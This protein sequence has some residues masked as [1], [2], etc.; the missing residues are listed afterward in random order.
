MEDRKGL[1]STIHCPVCIAVQRLVSR[2]VSQTNTEKKILSLPSIAPGWCWSTVLSV[3]EDSGYSSNSSLEPIL[4]C[5]STMTSYDLFAL[6]RL[7]KG[8]PCFIGSGQDRLSK[9]LEASMKPRWLTRSVHIDA[10]VLYARQQKNGWR[11]GCRSFCCHF[12]GM[13]D[14]IT[15]SIPAV[16]RHLFAPR[17]YAVRT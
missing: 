1:S 7:R 2:K 8:G 5:I 14:C 6:K 15:R 9:E 13:S 17:E 4:A 10:S 3:T 11:L 16:F 12:V